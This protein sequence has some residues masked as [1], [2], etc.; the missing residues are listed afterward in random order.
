M[1]LRISMVKILGHKGHQEHE[2]NLKNTKPQG[3]RGFKAKNF[4]CA[5]RVPSGLSLRIFF[6]F[7][8]S[9]VANF[10]N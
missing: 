6:V 4:P 8:V 10:L 7:L 5:P 2:E 9:F 1:N 3:A